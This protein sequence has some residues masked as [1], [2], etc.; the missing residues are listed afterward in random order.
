MFEFAKTFSSL[1]DESNVTKQQKKLYFVCGNEAAAATAYSCLSQQFIASNDLTSSSLYFPIIQIPRSDLYLRPECSYVFNECNFSTLTSQL[2]FLD[3][4]STYLDQ[5]SS[6]YD[7]NLI[8]VDHNKLISPWDGKFNDKIVAILDHHS[9]EGLYSYLNDKCRQIEKVGSTTSL[10][11]LHF[12]N[13]WEK[14]ISRDVDEK[15]WH[16]KLAK[17]LLAPIL[18]DTLLL[19]GSKGRVNNKDRE[20]TQFLLDVLKIP[21]SNQ[22]NFK[23]KYF[24]EIQAVKLNVTHFSNIDLLH[25]DYKEKDLDDFKIGISSVPWFLEGWINREND[26]INKLIDSIRSFSNK[27]KLDIFIIMLTYDHKGFKRE[28][29][30]L[31]KDDKFIRDNFIQQLE[32][33]LQLKRISLTTN[34][35]HIK[36]YKQEKT[37]ISRKELFP[38][39]IELILTT[40]I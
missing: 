12:K 15:S 16:N 29:V 6:K 26:D 38:L 28:L 11:V 1:I 25:K 18:V 7:V 10:V 30:F 20:A 40:N 13:D 35:D 14:Q 37:S 22:E 8:L 21:K 27:N 2:L 3:D 17:L 23:N 5:L 31:S 19:D 32:N 33:V 24:E 9:D 39:L 36:F 4:V 34:V